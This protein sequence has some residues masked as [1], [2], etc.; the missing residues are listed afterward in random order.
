MVSC[1]TSNGSPLP[2]GLASIY[3]SI[4]AMSNGVCEAAR[5]LQ[6]SAYARLNPVSPPSGTINITPLQPPALA[7]G[8]QP[9][10]ASF[11]I[12]APSESGLVLEAVMDGSLVCTTTA[13]GASSH[14]DACTSRSP[15]C[16]CLPAFA[17]ALLHS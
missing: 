17:H 7:C 1:R 13:A 3:L 9:L 8:N 14:A 11:A 4:V 16:R 15:V 6:A 10:S 5:P 2:S 12:T